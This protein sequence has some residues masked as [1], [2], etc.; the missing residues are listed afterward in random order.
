MKFTCDSSS[1]DEEIDCNCF[2]PCDEV[3]YA[4]DIVISDYQKD[5]IE[6]TKSEKYEEKLPFAF[7]LLYFLKISSDSVNAIYVIF[8]ETQF[9]TLMRSERYGFIDFISNCGGLMGLFM[10]ISI[11]SIIEIFYYGASF[12]YQIIFKFCCRNNQ[13]YDF[14]H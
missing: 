6:K 13:V 1:I 4:A 2:S 8:K 11:L 5:E 12:A 7:I 3:T 10:G 14:T 9:M